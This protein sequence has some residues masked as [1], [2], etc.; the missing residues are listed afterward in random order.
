MYDTPEVDE[1]Y[2]DQARFHVKVLSDDWLAPPTEEWFVTVDT[3]DRVDRAYLR[4]AFLEALSPPDY[5]LSEQHNVVHWG[6]AGAS[7]DLFIQL[8]GGAAGTIA[9]TKLLGFLDR[10]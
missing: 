8:A 6:A 2:T 9:A 4:D 1:R 10:I 5:R 3:G 7:Y